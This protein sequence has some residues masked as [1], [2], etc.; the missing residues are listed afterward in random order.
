MLSGLK[1]AKLTLRCLQYRYF[2]NSQAHSNNQLN[3]EP[4]TNKESNEKPNDT[5]NI[6]N[7]NRPADESGRNNKLL[8]ITA[9]VSL[10]GLGT[11]FAVM[12][13]RK[14]KMKEQNKSQE[15]SV[16]INFK[17]INE[18]IKGNE[19]VTKEGSITEEQAQM[20]EQVQIEGKPIEK[21]EPPTI[22]APGE[23]PI[24][25]TP[26]SIEESKE[27]NESKELSVEANIQPI[28]EKQ[29]ELSVE[30]NIQPVAEKS[31]EL[32]NIVETANEPLDAEIQNCISNMQ[33]QVKDF[34]KNISRYI[35]IPQLKVTLDN[36]VEAF[37]QLI[38]SKYLKDPKK[39][40]IKRLKINESIYHADYQLLVL[41]LSY[42]RSINGS[43]LCPGLLIGFIN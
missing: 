42:I 11:V 37:E 29:N 22:E 16:I 33:Q 25:E 36:S 43:L 32:V 12:W 10:I 26:K 9:G 34:P 30:I 27:A 28:T 15:E 40:L 8:M 3:I 1:H 24:V 18:E 13:K 41:L 35:E 39:N 21:E 20:E 19:E 14:K 7:I 5:E 4:K 23:T 38:L 6:S 17:E 31:K 2:T